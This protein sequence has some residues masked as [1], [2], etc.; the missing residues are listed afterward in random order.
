MLPVQ[1]LPLS[2]ESSAPILEVDGRLW[3]VDIGSA[4]SAAPDPGIQ[5]CGRMFYFDWRRTLQDQPDIEAIRARLGVP[6]HG[7]IGMDVLAKVDLFLD[8]ARGLAQVSERLDP[9]WRTYAQVPFVSN[10]SGV[11][12]YVEI[13]GRC[14]VARLCSAR[15]LAYHRGSIVDGFPSVGEAQDWCPRAGALVAPSHVVPLRIADV[16][17]DLRFGQASDAMAQA[18]ADARV[19]CHIGSELFR[20]RPSYVMGRRRM[21]ALAR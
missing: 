20:S 1:T 12:V 7:I 18:F 14:H 16:S 19:D 11:C 8:P 2:F 6:L 3:L 4:M 13:Q 15:G 21:I 9:D 10:P 5:L 17:L